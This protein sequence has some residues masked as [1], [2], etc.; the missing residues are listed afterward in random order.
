MQPTS[1]TSGIFHEKLGLDV[2]NQTLL[3]CLNDPVTIA[4]V[5]RVCIQWKKIMEALL[6]VDCKNWMTKPVEPFLLQGEYEAADSTFLKMKQGNL[7][8]HELI[9]SSPVEQAL[10]L[11]F[12][13][14]KPERVIKDVKDIANRE[15]LYQNGK[16]ELFVKNHLLKDSDHHSMFQTHSLAHPQSKVHPTRLA[17]QAGKSPQEYMKCSQLDQ[18]G[19]MAY[20]TEAFGPIY[21]YDSKQEHTISIE[22]PEIFQ[23]KRD[24]RQKQPGLHGKARYSC[25]QVCLKNDCVVASYKGTNSNGKNNIR[26]Y[27][28]SQAKLL[29]S[30][31]VFGHIALTD[32]HLIIVS[33]KSISFVNLETLTIKSS[34]LTHIEEFDHLWNWDN[35]ILKIHEK[36]VWVISK[37]C[38]H[39]ERWNPET[40]EQVKVLNVGQTQESKKFFPLSAALNQ[41]K[42][43]LSFETPDNPN[44]E[45]WDLKEEKIERKISTV[46]E[47]RLIDLKIDRFGYYHLAAQCLDKKIRVWSPYIRP[48][49]IR[50]LA[51]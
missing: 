2:L 38:S 46:A 3:Y 14:S 39:I 49:D 29:L 47:A 33:G 31:P 40:G 32:S 48:L 5:L 21:I 34:A 13:R 9:L 17:I 15:F 18:Q 20:T 8:L 6:Q 26:L 1:N 16:F 43:A 30:I 45:I 7:N 50:P 19:R 25:H 27:S 42:L 41:G 24:M 44:I 35:T 11:V 22:D 23:Q 28:I 51:Q 12:L 4:S 37:F 36:H 10:N